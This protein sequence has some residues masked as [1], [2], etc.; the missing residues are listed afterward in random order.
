MPRYELTVTTIDRLVG[1]L[2]RLCSINPPAY[3]GHFNMHAINV[4]ENENPACK[5]WFPGREDPRSA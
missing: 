2:F 1:E 3:M 5:G 4:L